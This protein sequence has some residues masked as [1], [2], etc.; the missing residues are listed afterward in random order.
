VVAS[1]LHRENLVR[2]MLTGFKRGAW[3]DGITQ[4]RHVVA[5]LILGGVLVFWWWQ[6]DTAPR[7]GSENAAQMNALQ[8]GARDN[9][10]SDD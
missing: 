4:A 7:A 9:E 6:W 3:A 5:A 8:L 1:W 2:A 10:E